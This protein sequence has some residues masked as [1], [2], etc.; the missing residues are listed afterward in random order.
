MFQYICRK[1]LRVRYKLKKFLI[2]YSSSSV[3]PV[4]MR[5]LISLPPIR[6]DTC[7]QTYGGYWILPRS[8]VSMCVYLH[9]FL[10]YHN[11]PPV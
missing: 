4:T 1:K 3:I 10:S 11:D 2:I 8:L 6:L 9:V 7:Q 5:V